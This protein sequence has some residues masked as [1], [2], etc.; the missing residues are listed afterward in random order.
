[1]NFSAVYD[2]FN[3][4]VTYTPTPP[5]CLTQNRVSQTSI[6]H[7]PFWLW[8]KLRYVPHELAV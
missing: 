6:M 4:C 5:F 1:M 2:R 8:P 3:V 7:S